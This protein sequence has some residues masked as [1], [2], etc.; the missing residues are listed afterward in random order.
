MAAVVWTGM[1]EIKTW[2]R[3]LPASLTTQGVHI[4]E[5]TTNG[6]EATIK[7]GYPPGP[8]RDGLSSTVT[9]E[10]FGVRGEVKNTAF[11]ASW[12]E[13]GTEARHYFSKQRGVKHLTG[14]MPAAN[15]FIPTMERA[16]RRMYDVDFRDLMTR[17]GLVV[18]GRA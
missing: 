6:A 7:A 8:L 1:E 15:L 4:V 3:N 13:N 2:L 17:E 14:K 5:A 10:G 11:N 16:R 12:F 18:T 9:S